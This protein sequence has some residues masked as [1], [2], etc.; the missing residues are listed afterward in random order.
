M[1]VHVCVCVNT[2]ACARFNMTLHKDVI[3]LC[4]ALV[5]SC[6]RLEVFLFTSM[7]EPSTEKCTL[8]FPRGSV[9]RA[10]STRPEMA[11]ISAKMVYIS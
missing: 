6:K 2:H 7:G 11:Y 1:H 10:A 4:K 3:L 8:Y 5:G 9:N